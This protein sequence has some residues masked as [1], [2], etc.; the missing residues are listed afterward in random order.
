M[1]SERETTLITNS[2]RYDPARDPGGGGR[3]CW[4]QG[5]SAKPLLE[6]FRVIVLSNSFPK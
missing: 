6:G 5:V 2:T 1:T 3:G 4:V